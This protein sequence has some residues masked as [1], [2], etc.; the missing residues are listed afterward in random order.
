MLLWM[1]NLDFCT[2]SSVAASSSSSAV[3]TVEEAAQLIFAHLSR[4]EMYEADEES[5]DE[6]LEYYG[7]YDLPLFKN[8]AEAALHPTC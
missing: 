2:V 7:G 5:D 1:V 6:H 4:D 3:A 8:V